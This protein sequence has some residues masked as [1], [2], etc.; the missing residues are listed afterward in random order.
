MR[1]DK[2]RLKGAFLGLAI[3]DAMGAPVEFMKRGTYEPVTG[4]RSGGKFRLNAGEWTD[5][6]AMALC[7]AQSLLDCQGFDPV[8]QL[9][10]YLLWMHEGYMS[11][12]GKMV[13]L[14]K[15]CMRTLVRYR[16]TRLSYTDITHEKFSGNGSLMRLAPI[17]MYY[18][19]DIE[20][21]VDY[22]ALSSKTTHGSPIAVDACRYFSYMLV[23][24]FNG[25]EKEMLFSDAFE[26]KVRAFFKNEPLHP[27]LDP[28]VA[29]EYQ[30]KKEEE[31]SNSGYVIDSLESAL[32]SFYH[33]STFK[34]AVLKAVNLGDD[35]DTVG[36]ITG[37]LAGACYGMH[38]IPDVW[39]LELA[40]KDD[41][42]D[43][44]N[45]LLSRF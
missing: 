18:A 14:G 21:A 27:A 36:A 33:T 2:N 11:C 8:D 23:S 17:C 1:Y 6:T 19:N 15:T 22:A 37:Q 4:Y 9:E 45:R 20:K 12:T 44:A 35:A 7:L 13:G 38:T 42:L 41:L 31:I 29:G 24:L 5:D 25:M 34:D 30:N 10:K 3:G 28:I 39:I 43:M 26:I 40:R 32:W 16:R